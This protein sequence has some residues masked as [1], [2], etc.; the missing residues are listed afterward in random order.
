VL[1]SLRDSD[2]KVQ[3]LV[4]F[5]SLLGL[6]NVKSETRTEWDGNDGPFVPEVLTEGWVHFGVRKDMVC[7]DITLDGE[8]KPSGGF[9]V[10]HRFVSNGYCH[11]KH[12]HHKSYGYLR[13]D[14][15]ARYLKD[16]L[17]ACGVKF[18]RSSKLASVDYRNENYC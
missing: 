2:V 12:N 1:P 14:A 3:H 16:I 6:S 5:G 10:E 11:E 8:Y 17:A 15:V 18:I 4:K 7:A 9:G 13:T